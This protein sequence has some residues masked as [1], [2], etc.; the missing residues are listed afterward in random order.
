MNK[1][2]DVSRQAVL[3]LLQI[4]NF[5]YIIVKGEASRFRNV[6]LVLGPTNRTSEEYPP[7]ET[8]WLVKSANRFALNRWKA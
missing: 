2:S 5:I 4:S 1:K 3:D 8:A 7:K 6:F